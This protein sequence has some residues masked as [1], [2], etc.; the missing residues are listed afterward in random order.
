[1]DDTT[2]R[3][4]LK[5][6]RDTLTASLA[7][8]PLPALPELPGGDDEHGGVFVTLRNH[9]RLRGCIGEFR[10]DRN[11]A[12]AV[13]RM[14][15]AVLSDPRFARCPVTLSEVPELSIEISVLSPMRRT[16][17]PE[18]LVPG[19]HGVYVRHG[20]QAGCFLPQVALEQG[21]NARQLLDYCCAHKAGLP[22]DAWTRPD[23]EVY[24]FTAEILDEDQP[25]PAH[26]AGG[27]A[28]T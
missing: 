22:E 16:Q 17:N 25:P 19:V 27:S 1:M 10:T 14:A 4:L 12:A 23:T 20:R 21:W 6:A 15:E 2:R 8:N 5:L 28:R 24:L 18:Q 13:Q 9:G 11:L 3:A 26:P 7:G